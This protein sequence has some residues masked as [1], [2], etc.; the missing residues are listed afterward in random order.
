[1]GDQYVD[2]FE[3]FKRKKVDSESK[4][5]RE[6]SRAIGHPESPDEIRPSGFTTNRYERK[7]LHP[8]EGT[9]PQDA[10]IPTGDK[11]KGFV[12]HHHKAKSKPKPEDLKKPKGFES[13]SW[14]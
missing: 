12:T 9:E 10:D 8:E 14:G 13:H 4:A 5:K 6:I 2:P 1:M 11:P 7:K 3:A